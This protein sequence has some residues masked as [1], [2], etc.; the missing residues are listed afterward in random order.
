MV[1]TVA[2]QSKHCPSPKLALYLSGAQAVQACP[3]PEYPAGQAETT[4]VSIKNRINETK[5]PS[6]E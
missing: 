2:A 1:S 3:V 5:I 6:L 4:G